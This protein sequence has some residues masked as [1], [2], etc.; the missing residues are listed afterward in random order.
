MWVPLWALLLISSA[1]DS[2]GRR[3]PVDSAAMPHAMSPIGGAATSNGQEDNDEG[4]N[5]L[6]TTINSAAVSPRTR[7]CSSPHSQ[8]SAN[9]RRNNNRI[10]W[11]LPSFTRRRTSRRKAPASAAGRAKVPTPSASDT[12]PSAAFSGALASFVGAVLV[13]GGT[14]GVWPHVAEASPFDPRPPP[15]PSKQPFFEGWFIRWGC[16][17]AQPIPCLLA[18]TLEAAP[19]GGWLS[20]TLFVP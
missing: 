19:A 6:T 18:M 5:D 16:V 1:Y 15:R 8:C 10:A 13:A 7:R 17:A 11:S 2:Y 9:R 3:T 20:F 12:V 14:L 4:S